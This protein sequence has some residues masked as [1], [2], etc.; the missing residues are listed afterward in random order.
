MRKSGGTTN[1][2]RVEMTDGLSTIRLHALYSAAI[3]MDLHEPA[4]QGQSVIPNQHLYSVLREPQQS[5][6][7]LQINGIKTTITSDVRQQSRCDRGGYAHA[8]WALNLVR[9]QSGVGDLLLRL[10]Q[11]ATSCLH[12]AP[13]RS[14]L[15]TKA[16]AM[17]CWAISALDGGAETVPGTAGADAAGHRVEK[18]LAARALAKSDLAHAGQC[19]YGHLVQFGWLS[20]GGSWLKIACRR[21]VWN[22][23]MAG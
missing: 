18:E 23:V 19:S 22:A 21:A 3:R 11:S 8:R 17:W 1:H 16:V 10:E 2:L 7:A 6:R 5:N 15:W 9:R 20:E 14:W 13:R 4:A 12:P